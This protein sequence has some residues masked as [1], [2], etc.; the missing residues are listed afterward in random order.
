M[1]G[2]EPGAVGVPRWAGMLCAMR[3]GAESLLPGPGMGAQLMIA[4]PGADVSAPS[5]AR[6]SSGPAV[7]PVTISSR[8]GTAE[9][10]SRNFE[11][12]PL[13]RVC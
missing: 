1:T 3:A 10:S 8:V 6:R 5:A 2:R 11:S 7:C 12:C 4:A 9:R 13:E